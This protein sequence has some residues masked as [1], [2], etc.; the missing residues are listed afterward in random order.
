MALVILQKNRKQRQNAHARNGLEIRQQL[1]LHGCLAP[2]NQS[3]QRSCKGSWRYAG[4]VD[5]TEEYKEVDA[6]DAVGSEHDY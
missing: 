4:G 3:Y 5:Q 2:Y 1:P 6:V